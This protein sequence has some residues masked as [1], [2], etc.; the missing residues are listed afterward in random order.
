MQAEHSGQVGSG[1]DCTKRPVVI[2]SDEMAKWPAH[3]W[4]ERQPD[5]TG[6]ASVSQR[7]DM[8]QRP[9]IVQRLARCLPPSCATATIVV[10]PGPCLPRVSL[11]LL[12]DAAGLGNVDQQQQQ[13]FGGCWYIKDWHLASLCDTLAPFYRVPLVFSDDWCVALLLHAAAHSV[14]LH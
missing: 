14:H 10:E 3:R 8:G 6:P 12:P 5:D 11:P 13:V 4:H 1:T 9:V 7:C 2:R